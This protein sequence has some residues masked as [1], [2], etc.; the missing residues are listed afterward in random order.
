MGWWAMVMIQGCFLRCSGLVAR[1]VNNICIALQ[2]SRTNSKYLQVLLQPAVLNGHQLQT[3]PQEE[4]DLRAEA[5]H[6]GGANV[7]AVVVVLCVAGHAESVLV[8]RKVAAGFI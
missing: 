7:P 1:W 3:I 5:D 8:V 6:V 4:V 2:W